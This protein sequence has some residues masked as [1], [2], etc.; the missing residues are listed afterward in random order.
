[1]YLRLNSEMVMSVVLDRVPTMV[2]TT[3]SGWLSNGD[4]AFKRGVDEVEEGG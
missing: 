1:M 3:M 2:R 4:A